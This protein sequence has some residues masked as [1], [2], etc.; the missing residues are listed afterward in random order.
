MKGRSGRTGDGRTSE[1]HFK[2]LDKHTVSV[3]SG[4]RRR[5]M[6]ALGTKNMEMQRREGTAEQVRKASCTILVRLQ[7]QKK[8]VTKGHASKLRCN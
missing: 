1:P 5:R 2:R 3:P 8:D 7:N 6:G 4:R